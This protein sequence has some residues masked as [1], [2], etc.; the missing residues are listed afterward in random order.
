MSGRDRRQARRAIEQ[1]QHR[2]ALASPP[3]PA[4]GVLGEPIGAAAPLLRQDAPGPA[5]SRPTP[6]PQAVAVPAPRVV[7]EPG[8][9]PTT[10]EHVGSAPTPVP[11]L[12]ALLQQR[13]PSPPAPDLPP[14]HEQA[15]DLR[16]LLAPP[17]P[18]AAEQLRALGITVPT[19]LPAHLPLHQRLLFELIK[20]HL[21]M[22][23]DYYPLDRLHSDLPQLKE[24]VG[25]VLAFERPQGGA[26]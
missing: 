26:A 12:E 4:A 16:D 18:A 17:S 23:Q 10:A 2:P 1:H 15:Q 8:P 24:L 7:A 13:Y 11:S 22:G 5:A 14:P 19:P 3:P 6:P 20:V 21:Q 9:P 25:E